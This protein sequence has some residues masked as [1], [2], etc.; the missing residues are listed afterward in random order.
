MTS[1]IAPANPQKYDSRMAFQTLG[2][3]HWSQGR[4]VNAAVGDT[5]YIYESSPTQKLI[6][7]TEILARDEVD[8][9][10]DDSDFTVGKENY[11]MMAPWFRLSL[12]EAIPDG[13]NLEKLRSFGVAGNVQGL[14]SIDD[15][16]A[17]RIEE[18]ISNNNSQKQQE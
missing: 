7:K 6:L 5:V 1:W 4:N 18:F 2:E 14:R 12:M 3:V 17:E 16:I 15:M 11:A 9:H 10:I 13:L 8:N